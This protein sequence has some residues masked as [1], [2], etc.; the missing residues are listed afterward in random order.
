MD[1]ENEVLMGTI[2]IKRVMDCEGQDY[3]EVD[4]VPALST[5]EAVGILHLAANELMN[6]DD[7]D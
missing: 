5:V 7:D 6:S 2:T 1:E 3:L 4:T